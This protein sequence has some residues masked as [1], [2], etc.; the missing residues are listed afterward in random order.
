M[1]RLNQRRRFGMRTFGAI[2]MMADPAD[3][4]GGG[5]PAPADPAPADPSPSDPAPADPAPND[6]VT[7]YFGADIP[8]DWRGQMLTK[9]G[10]EA[11]SDEFA[12]GMKQLERS[13]D[14]GALIKSS[15]S[16]QDMIRKGEISNGLPE[17]P[18][19]EQMAEY[20]EAHGVPATAEDYQLQL[21]EGLVL[22][23]ADEKIMGGIYEI[24]HAANIPADAVSAMTNAMLQGRQVE[25]DARISQDGIDAQNGINLMKESWGGDY[26]MNMNMVSGLF[27]QMPEAIKDDVMSAR[28]PDGKALFNSPEAMNA[29]ADWARKLNPSATVVPN[30]ANP[31][32]DMN[33]KIAEYE[34]Q[35][36]TPE[37]SKN[38]EGQQDYMKLI[39][40]R[41]Q[42]Q[43]RA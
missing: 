14:I 26:Q 17:N 10:F 43:N 32:K 42:M 9:A 7:D 35:M 33:S 16:A 34:N 6:P 36:G 40:A 27:N 20:R 29:F 23:E 22:G 24:A 15:L 2:H 12:K 37:W 18:S 25:A 5:D 3:P 8:E 11:E 1:K 21:D 39:D 4:G 19:D 31:M 28:L 30:S 13:S 38:V 41:D